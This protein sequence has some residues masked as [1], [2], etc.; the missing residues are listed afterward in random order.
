M[1]RPEIS[2]ELS[3]SY[4]QLNDALLHDRALLQREVLIWQRLVRYLMVVVAVGTI[5][6]VGQRLDQRGWYIIGGAAAAYF[7]FNAMTALAARFLTK[8]KVGQSLQ[9]SILGADIAMIGALV[10]VSGPP[11]QYHRILLLGFLVLLLTG[12]Y[13]GRRLG[14]WALVL[15]LTAYLGVSFLGTPFIDGPRPLMPVVAFNAALFFFSGGVTV[16]TLGSFRERMDHFRL[17]CKRFEL[18]DMSGEFEP[19]KDRLPD[20]L[21]LVGRSFNEMRGRLIELI[22]T[23]ALTGVV[24][25]RSFETR[26]SREWRHAKRRDSTLALL[27]IDIDHFKLVNDTHGHAAG[28]IALQELAEIMNITARETDVVARF[29]GDEFVV[30]LPDTGWQ[31]AM[32]FAERLRKNV[33]DHSF[34]VEGAELD[35][36][37]SIGVALARGTDPISVVDLLEYADRSL[38]KA[39][40]GGRNRISA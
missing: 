13:F 30:L 19:E 12:F 39:K 37:I 7:V 26:L 22:G 6:L 36:T 33:D 5:A 24:N 2:K 40:S 21:T 15:L 17:M 29:G 32:T 8:E 10:Y 34:M 18:G 14:L 20:D 4:V 16:M 25:R 27:M 1:A 23:D 31:G 28:D 9:A 38:Y 11:S 35:I 3:S